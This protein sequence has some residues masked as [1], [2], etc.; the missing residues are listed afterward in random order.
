MV[1]FGSQSPCSTKEL[2]IMEMLNGKK[3]SDSL[4][5]ELA[6]ALGGDRDHANS[7]IKRKRLGK[8]WPGQLYD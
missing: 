7:L 2:L 4:E 6:L 3:L 8:S 1:G 5:D